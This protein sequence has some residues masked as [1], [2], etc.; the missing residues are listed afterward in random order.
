MAEWLLS[1]TTLYI[2]GVTSWT[3]VPNGQDYSFNSL[4]RVK[5]EQQF[6]IFCGHLSTFTAENRRKIRHFT[7]EK[8]VLNFLTGSYYT[9]FKKSRQT[10]Y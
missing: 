7:T 9:G 5:I 2:Q 1:N 6:L 10:I 3:H 8:N 4:T